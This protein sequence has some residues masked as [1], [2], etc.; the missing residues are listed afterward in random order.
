MSPRVRLVISAVLP[1][2]S[3]RRC[4]T[5]GSRPSLNGMSGSSSVAPHRGPFLG[6][7]TT[8]VRC[9]R[10][11]KRAYAVG[12]AGNIGVL[13]YFKNVHKRVLWS[14]CWRAINCLRVRRLG[15]QLVAVRATVFPLRVYIVIPLSFSRP[16][17]V[18][19][20]ILSFA[21][22]VYKF[23]FLHSHARNSR[24]YGYALLVGRY[25]PRSC[26][27]LVPYLPRQFNHP[28]TIHQPSFD[29]ISTIDYGRSMVHR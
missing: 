20:L 2:T 28:S 5:V 15:C 16:V 9:I 11:R 3:P 19:P 21:I 10:D 26:I 18:S 27:V 12:C 24:Q 7:N 14:I 1:S 13:A 17:I 4:L 6:K 8:S 29:H 25:L 23:D 22:I